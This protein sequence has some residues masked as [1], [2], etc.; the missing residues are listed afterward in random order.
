MND[1]GF[2]TKKSC[3]M[4]LDNHNNF[5]PHTLDILLKLYCH[6]YKS[7]SFWDIDGDL[8]IF[9][10]DEAMDDDLVKENQEKDKI[11][12]KPDKNKRRGEARKSLKQLQW[13]KEEKPKKTQKE[14]SKTHTR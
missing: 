11:E 9:D 2:L 14:W 12:S 3:T 13:I 10:A 7:G 8:V 4:L 6:Y 5:M 1:Y